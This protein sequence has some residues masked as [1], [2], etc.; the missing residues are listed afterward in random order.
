MNLDL[1]NL[2]YE[3]AKAKNI[4]KASEKLHVFLVK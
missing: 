1:W 3:V 4:S 2:F